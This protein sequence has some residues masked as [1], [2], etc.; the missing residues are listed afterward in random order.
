MRVV[1]ALQAMGAVHSLP[2]SA[3]F[4]A[5]DGNLVNTSFEI[6]LSFE[7]ERTTF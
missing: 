6:K 7:V 4:L 2:K 5:F 1:Q 3:S